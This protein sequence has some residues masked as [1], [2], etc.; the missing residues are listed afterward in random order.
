[1][2]V[3]DFARAKEII[4]NHRILLLNDNHWIELRNLV[5]QL[6]KEVIHGDIDLMLSVA[7]SLFYK[8]DLTE[9]PIIVE[10]L[11]AL[12]ADLDKK[13]TLF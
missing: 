11:E 6:P 13:S 12:T 4:K 9:L 5:E 3:K 1:M 7:Y 8:A 10:K 2:E